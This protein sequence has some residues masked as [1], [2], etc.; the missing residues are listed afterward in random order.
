MTTESM[1][2]VRKLAEKAFYTGAANLIAAEVRTG[3][4]PPLLIP[5]FVSTARDKARNYAQR[6]Q[7]NEKALHRTTGEEP[8]V[9]ESSSTKTQPERT[10]SLQTMQHTPLA[11]ELSGMAVSIG[12][13]AGKVDAESWE[14]LNILRSNLKAA[15]EMASNLESNLEVPR[16]R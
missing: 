16:A 6:L 7:I 13:L 15:A 14:F 5:L 8:E 4:T 2:Y 3:I 10:T 1:N 9:E 12:V 11:A